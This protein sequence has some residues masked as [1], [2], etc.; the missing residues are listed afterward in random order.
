MKKF[1]IEQ[2]DKIRDLMERFHACQDDITAEQL[3][4]EALRSFQLLDDFLMMGGP[5]PKAWEFRSPNGQPCA[6]MGERRRVRV[7]L[8][9]KRLKAALTG[10]ECDCDMCKGGKK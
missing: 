8:D 7:A 10:K 1:S 6:S 5:L 4:D 9:E 2:L 3:A